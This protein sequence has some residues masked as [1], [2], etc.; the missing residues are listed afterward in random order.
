M[1]LY[2][3]L[4]R[5]LKKS[6]C[7]FEDIKVWQATIVTFPFDKQEV[8]VY[9]LEQLTEKDIAYFNKNLREKMMMIKT[10][11][12]DAASAILKMEL[13]YLSASDTNEEK[14]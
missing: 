14:Q 7:S 13:A 3:R 6:G 4:E 2:D 12:A 9:L 10:L 1:Q 11:D 5:L 8:L